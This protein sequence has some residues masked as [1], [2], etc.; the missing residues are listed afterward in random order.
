ML[1]SVRY[2]L[3]HPPYLPAHRPKPDRLPLPFRL[4][5]YMNDVKSSWD[6]QESSFAQ[7]RVPDRELV[8]RAFSC[9]LRRTDKED[10][11]DLRL[12]LVGKVVRDVRTSLEFHRRLG[13]DSPEGAEDEQH[14]EATTPLELRVARDAAKLMRQINPE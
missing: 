14:A 9:T 5:C 3:I 11:M 10:E 6:T 7:R 12:D 1:S 8:R 13:L 2:L 4:P